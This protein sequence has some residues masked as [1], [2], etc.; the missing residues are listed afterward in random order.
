MRSIRRGIKSFWR[1]PVGNLVVVLL[2][3]VCLAFS[4]SMLVVKLAADTQVEDIKESVGNYSEVRISSAYILEVFDQELDKGARQRLREARSMNEEEELED[5]AKFLLPEEVADTFARQEHILTF[6][7]IQNAGIII[8]NAVNSEL[9]PLAQYATDEELSRRGIEGLNRQTLGNLFVFEGNTNGSSASDF[10]NGSKKLIEGSYFTYEDYLKN[11][12]VALVEKNMAE[13]NELGIGD[14]VEAVIVGGG[15]NNRT[16]EIEIIGIY[17]TIEAERDS[18]SILDYNPAG[19]KLFAPLSVVQ[20][21]NGT[22]GYVELGSY[23]FD[24]V[25]STAALQKAFG[26]DVADGN[27]Y[28]LITDYADYEKISEPLEKVG[29]TSMIGLIGA[30]G[31]CALIILLAMAIIIGGRTRELG[32]LKAIGATGRQVIVQYAAEVICIC[33]VSVILATGATVLISQGIGDWLLS[34]NVQTEVVKE[35]EEEPQE[36][37]GNYLT[38]RKLYK[39]GGLY[40]VAVEEEDAVNLNVIYQ[41]DLLLYGILILFGISLL[42]M[43]VPVIW[44]TRLRPARVLSME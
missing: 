2:L 32:V 4:L 9:A 23:Y 28:E 17:E 31:A 16:M 36:Y 6:D 5:R 40:S 15:R 41:G 43:A 39:E 24:N 3:F 7:K 20:E 29:K 11:N 14:Y 38:D 37:T 42:G 8:T 19:N 1:H 34:G 27:R 10:L 33:L 25:D 18:G 35:G 26:K 22:P 30:L 13:D 12:R 21:L 44:I